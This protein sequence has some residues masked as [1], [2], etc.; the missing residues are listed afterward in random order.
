MGDIAQSYLDFF[1]NAKVLPE[2][3]PIKIILLQSPY[4]RVIFDRPIGTSWF[5]ISQF[6]LVSKKCY[7]FEDAEISRK[8]IEKVIEEEAKLLNGKYE[9]I[10]LGGFSQGACMSLLIGLT[11]E[12]LIGGVISL[13]GYLFS[14]IKIREENKDLKIFVGHGEADN[15]ISYLA[16]REKMK[17]IENFKGYRGYSYPGKAHGIFEKEVQDLNNFLTEF[18]K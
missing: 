8:R 7:S 2:G 9:N 3:V 10:Y 15:V 13:S 5:N 4:K 12:H 6:P 1:G 11:Y 16:S 14:E 17:R 18:M